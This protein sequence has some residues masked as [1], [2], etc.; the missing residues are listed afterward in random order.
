MRTYSYIILS[1]QSRL[2]HRTQPGCVKQSAGVSQHMLMQH[3]AVYVE[4]LAVRSSFNVQLGRRLP[5]VG[6][7]AQH[8]PGSHS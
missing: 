4:R 6:A 7:F 8:P 2:L 5:H 3:A 1:I